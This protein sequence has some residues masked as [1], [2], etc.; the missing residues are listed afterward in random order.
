ESIARV[1]RGYTQYVSDLEQ[2]NRKALAMLRN[3]L[4][5]PISDY[6]TTWTLESN[7][8]SQN[9][10][11]VKPC[12]KIKL[13]S[14]SQEPFQD[15]LYGSK[16]HTL[17]ARKLIQEIEDGNYY[18]N[19][20]NDKEFIRKKIVD[21]AKSYNLSSKYTSFI[22][23]ETPIIDDHE[24]AEALIVVEESA[25]PEKCKKIVACQSE[26]GCIELSDTV[27]DE[28]DAP[29]EEIINTIKPKLKNKKVQLPNLPSI[30]GTAI[31]PSYLKKFAPS[32]KDEWSD[33][34]DKARDKDAEKEFEEYADNYVVDNCVMKVIKH[35]KGSAVA[36][37]RET[38]TPEIGLSKAVFIAVETPII[39]DH[40]EAEALIVVEES[41]SPEK[42]KKIV[43]CQSE[44]GCIE[45]SDT[46][47]DELDAPKEEIINTIK[48]KLK[49]K[50]V[51]LPNLP[52]ILGTAIN[53]SYLKKFAPSYKDE[54]SD[55]YDK[56]RDKDAE[57][58][59]EEYADNYV[60]D[61][62]VMKVIKHKKGSAVATVRETATPEI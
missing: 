22:A 3:S 31:N 1:G 44:D 51:Q 38:A 18:P 20:A 24:E 25:S 35:K 28:L 41:A 5:P 54:W 52:S 45:L 49:N 59:F 55:K 42:C 12:D 11:D 15:R 43:A 13:K 61:N 40:E 30:L 48:P 9:K 47:C 60:V 8:E 56:A 4:N 53:P 17:A 33:K 50:K 7:E 36:T 6:K 26:D 62:C 10:K 27:C 39:D 29:K 46:V 34:Y 57:K 37:V 32:Y 19:H 16:F 2:M 23:V 21:L 14:N 58:E